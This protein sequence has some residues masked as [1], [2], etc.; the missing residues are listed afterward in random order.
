M[1]ESEIIVLRVIEGPDQGRCFPVSDTC[2]GGGQVQCLVQ[3]SDPAVAGIHFRLTR[4]GDSFT[5]TD[6]TTNPDVRVNDRVVKSRKLSVGDRISVGATVLVVEASSSPVVESGETPDIKVLGTRT[7]PI[8]VMEPEPAVKADPVPPAE[9]RRPSSPKKEIRLRAVSTPVADPIPGP[10]P[11]GSGYGWIIALVMLV[12]VGAVGM[13][14]RDIKGRDDIRKAVAAASAYATSHPDDVEGIIRRYESVRDRAGSRYAETARFI[15]SEIVRLQQ[16]KQQSGELYVRQLAEMDAGADEHRNQHRYDEAVAV[17]ENPPAGMDRKRV[18]E[19]RKTLLAAI[20]D[21]QQAYRKEQTDLQQ[22]RLEEQRVQQQALA[23]V[24]L[25][26]MIR[27]VTDALVANQST[28]AARLLASALTDPMLNSATSRIDQ[29]LGQIRILE[30]IDRTVRNAVTGG[31]S[32][33]EPDLKQAPPLVRAIYALRLGDVWLAKTHLKDMGDHLLKG[34][35]D[36]LAQVP[37]AQAAAE[38]AAIRDLAGAWSLVARGPVRRIPAPDVCVEQFTAFAGGEPA[39]TVQVAARA[40]RDGAHR[41]AGTRVA[42]LY[43]P[44]FSAVAVWS[45]PVWNP[46]RALAAMGGVRIIHRD[47]KTCFAEIAQLPAGDTVR[48]GFFIPETIFLEPSGGEPVAVWGRMA[49]VVPCKPLADRQIAFT[50]EPTGD[51]LPPATGDYVFVDQAIPEGPRLL[52]RPNQTVLYGAD[53]ESGRGPEWLDRVETRVEGG[54]LLIESDRDLRGGVAASLDSADVLLKLAMGR[55]PV[56]VSAAIRIQPSQTV[57]IKVGRIRLRLGGRE[58]L[59]GIYVAGR[60]V[61]MIPPVRQVPGKQTMVMLERNGPLLRWSVDGAAAECAVGWLA[62]NESL[63]SIGFSGDG[64]WELDNVV[65]EKVSRGFDA[66]LQAVSVDQMDVL[67]APGRDTAW[68]SVRPDTPVFFFSVPEG[69]GSVK[70]AGSAK[71]VR[72]LGDWIH[73]RLDAGARPDAGVRVSLSPDYPVTDGANRGVQEA[74]G[75]ERLA[76]NETVLGMIE[77]VQGDVAEIRLDTLRSLP[78]RGFMGVAREPVM[79]PYQGEVM[80]LTWGRSASCEFRQDGLRMTVMLPAGMGSILEANRPVVFSRNMVPENRRM[81]PVGWMREFVPSGVAR[82]QTFWA[83]M[84][85]AWT[86]T[87]D[88]L[89]GKAGA[90]MPV[91]EMAEGVSGNVQYDVDVGIELEAGKP[92]DPR[93]DTPWLRDLMVVLK[94]PGI[95]SSVTIALGVTGSG[96]V[97][98]TG[99]GVRV[100][101]D[102]TSLV[103][104]ARLPGD[105][106]V[107][108][109]AGWPDGAPALAPGGLYRVRIRKTG[110]HLA[111]MVNGKRVVLA[112][113]KGMD[114]VYTVLA[115][116][117]PQG[118]LRIA[119]VRARE[120]PL[121]VPVPDTEPATGYAGY[122]LASGGNHVLVDADTQGLAMSRKFSLM[123]VGNV[124]KGEQSLTVM[125]KRV[126][127]G[128]VVE[129]GPLTA[130]LMLNEGGEAIK[131]GLKLMSGTVPVELMLTGQRLM[132][133]QEGL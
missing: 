110:D 56:R 102:G 106:T 49:A 22:R 88:G 29:A 55:E 47:G 14:L 126:G 16:Q 7:M 10:A 76:D 83:V 98:V 38:Q 58:D 118:G 93:S 65:V 57:S 8:Q 21:E 51:W 130:R 13:I 33:Y 26:D 132:N 85:T 23:G 46:S 111:V 127:S 75:T 24:R 74:A 109:D 79:H 66:S 97:A 32:D 69:T 128:T 84:N 113:I 61:Q 114:G 119:R 11:A 40:V 18:L 63:A 107:T 39:E 31:Q 117:A 53:F 54:C 12:I 99:N 64:K 44:L 129:Q 112:Q 121:S 45:T 71:V 100:F 17:Y 28:D 78:A 27:Q 101:S 120:I 50:I 34:S 92:Q 35:L 15:E 131:P 87:K 9:P 123:S 104:P 103:C 52:I 124:V 115:L 86:E 95:G 108:V 90:L 20:R 4:R 125:L 67:V 73:C 133:L 36:E 89:R 80:N 77:R 19:S 1:A 37:D 6:L 81:D 94:F 43:V 48:V 72:P 42:Q 60:P 91:L 3:L 30:A 5:L 68:M 2:F 25:N 122:V 62:G 41:H 82:K 70:R 116:A 105:S 59:Q 96:R